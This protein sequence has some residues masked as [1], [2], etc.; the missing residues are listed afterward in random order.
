MQILCVYSL[1][2][3]IIIGECLCIMISFYFV[4][5]DIR[6]TKKKDFSKKMI[7]AM[8]DFCLLLLNTS[9]KVKTKNREKNKSCTPMFIPLCN[10]RKIG[11]CSVRL[12]VFHDEK[13][14]TWAIGK[15]VLVYFAVRLLV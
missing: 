6:K 5:E 15:I 9:K 12:Y 1:P 14:R 8:K 7:K 2:K 10:I 13:I 11:S 4:I 3:Q